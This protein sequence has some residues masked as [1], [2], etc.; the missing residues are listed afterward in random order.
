MPPRASNASTSLQSEAVQRRPSAAAAATPADPTTTDGALCSSSSSSSSATAA[1]R[2]PADRPVPSPPPPQPVV[3]PRASLAARKRPSQAE[4][5]RKSLLDTKE[6]RLDSERRRRRDDAELREACV[7]IRNVAEAL[8]SVLPYEVGRRDLQGWAA[9]LLTQVSAVEGRIAQLVGLPAV[10]PNTADASSPQPPLPP[11]HDRLLDPHAGGPTPRRR[12]SAQPGGG[13]AARPQATLTPGGAGA[14]AAGAPQAL[15]AS[16]VAQQPEGGGASPLPAEVSGHCRGMSVNGGVAAA[17]YLVLEAAAERV[18]AER[19]VAFL[20]T[21]RSDELQA[22]CI[23]NG[24]SGA[25][26]GGKPSTL[27]VSST[28][29]WPGQVFSTGVAANVTNVYSDSTYDTS[30][31]KKFGY[32]TRSILCVPIPFA[33]GR[34][35]A[36]QKCFGVL[37]VVNKNRGTADFTAEDEATLSHVASVVAYLAQHYPADVVHSHYDPA[38]LHKLLAFRPLPPQNMA[39]PIHSRSKRLVYRYAQSGHYKPLLPAVPSAAAAPGDVSAAPAAAVAS[40]DPALAAAARPGAPPPSVLDLQAGITEVDGHIRAL[41]DAWLRTVSLNVEYQEEQANSLR[42][43]RTLREALRE[44]K[45]TIALQQKQLAE[46]YVE[47][48]SLKSPANK[49]HASAAS[50]PAAAAAAA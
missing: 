46:C 3:P 34:S 31:D 35:S 33:E 8:R 36:D 27:K 4:R 42:V 38:P 23:V 15:S 6:A 32:R 10:P 22:F 24:G 40:T 7:G 17:L 13:D 29:G 30:L 25:G 48:S 1:T 19:G 28:Q 21:R 12:V 50:G 14:P 11:A 5:E 37:Q 2:S 41:E 18:R 39:I 9:A 43:V 44:R 45:L 16:P 20:H 47:L 26:A 49:E